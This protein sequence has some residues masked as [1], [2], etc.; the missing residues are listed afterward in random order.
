MKQKEEM[1]DLIKL[2]RL[3]TEFAAT[4][5]QLQYLADKIG[6]ELEEILDDPETQYDD[7]SEFWDCA[8]HLMF[9]SDQIDELKKLGVDFNV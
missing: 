6:V 8:D 1:I 7:E 9:L 2:I 3:E 5:Y 4:W